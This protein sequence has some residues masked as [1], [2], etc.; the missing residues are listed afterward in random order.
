[1]DELTAFA[2]F[3]KLLQ[4][5]CTSVSALY[6]YHLLIKSLTVVPLHLLHPTAVYPNLDLE[7]P[8]HPD[9]ISRR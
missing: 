2:Q 7:K 4:G 6:A 5:L 3:C 9:Y 1:M 8:C